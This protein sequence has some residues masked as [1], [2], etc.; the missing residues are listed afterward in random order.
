MNNNTGKP[1]ISKENARIYYDELIKNFR[2]DT[3]YYLKV[4]IL[5]EL[6]EN[7]ILK[8]VT[9]ISDFKIHCESEGQWKWLKDRMEIRLKNGDIKEGFIPQDIISGIELL[10]KQRNVAVHKK[11][12]NYADYL[13][14]FNTVAK[15]INFFSNINIPKDIVNICEGEGKSK[16]NKP[17][18]NVNNDSNKKTKAKN[19]NN[20]SDY[21]FVNTGIGKDTLRVRKWAYNEKHKFVSAGDGEPHLRNI[22]KLKKSDKIFAYISKKG[23]VGFGEVEEEA[24]PV[25]EYFKDK[26]NDNPWENYPKADELIVKVKWIKKFDENN[27]KWERNK[28]LFAKQNNVCKLTDKTTIEYLEKEFE[29]K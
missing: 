3:S 13:G 1:K 4:P 20:W 17:K 18:I 19:K 5:K 10:S 22:K 26:P 24:V 28:G 25:K 15:T 27:A 6:I 2:Y 9:K 21:W 29:I 8:E 23:Y 14:L 11:D 12:I 16:N 7:E